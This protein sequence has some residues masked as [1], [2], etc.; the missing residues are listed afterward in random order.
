MAIA[1]KR[2]THHMNAHRTPGAG[3]T[4]D[5]VKSAVERGAKIEPFNAAFV[6]IY[7]KRPE[8]KPSQFTDYGLPQFNSASLVPMTVAKAA[9]PDLDL[10]PTTAPMA[11]Q[12]RRPKP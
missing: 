4:I 2:I 11:E 10:A 7:M 9:L 1:D 8:V 6:K 5:L 3:W 12:R